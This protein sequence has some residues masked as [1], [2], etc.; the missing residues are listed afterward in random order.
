MGVQAE[1]NVIF[2]LFMFAIEIAALIS[3]TVLGIC[4]RALFVAAEQLASYTLAWCIIA[5][6]LA[7]AVAGYIIWTLI[8]LCQYRKAHRARHRELQ[9]VYSGQNAGESQAGQAPPAGGADPAN[10]HGLVNIRNT[11]TLHAIPC[12]LP[13]QYSAKP[14]R[15]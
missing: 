1:S 11:C 5:L 7:I 8:C 14:S 15:A 12:R 10:P 6:I 2:L 3:L 13:Q 4:I 9:P